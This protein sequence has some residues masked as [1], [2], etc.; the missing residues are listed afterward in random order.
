MKKVIII[1]GLILLVIGI[2]YR[3]G[4]IIVFWLT[5]PKEVG[6]TQNEIKLFD[7]IKRELNI[8]NIERAPKY[9]ISNPK[10]TVSYSLFMKDID[11]IKYNDSL[12]FIAKKI[13]KKIDHGIKL[14]EKVYEIGIFFECKKY[15]PDSVNFKFSRKDLK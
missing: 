1:I 2:I 4:F 15:S 10:D 13:A 12:K 8:K 9:N 5:T 7:E 6:L 3:Y 11:C 14:D